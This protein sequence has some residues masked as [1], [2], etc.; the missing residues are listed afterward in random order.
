MMSPSLYI[1]SFSSHMLLQFPSSM[2]IN[3]RQDALLQSCGL[4]SG[5]ALGFME[6]FKCLD[7]ELRRQ[8]ISQVTLRHSVARPLIPQAKDIA[9]PGRPL[10]KPLHDGL[11]AREAPGPQRP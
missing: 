2:P 3:T 6:V 10:D 7:Q 8:G 11:R 9:R 4:V 5:E 1:R